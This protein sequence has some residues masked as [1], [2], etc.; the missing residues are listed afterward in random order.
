MEGKQSVEPE[1]YLEALSNCAPV[2]TRLGRLFL[3]Y[4]SV[5]AFLTT[6]FPILAMQSKEILDRFDKS[7]DSKC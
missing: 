5:W 6:P 2:G 4:V 3:E 7:L 1:Y